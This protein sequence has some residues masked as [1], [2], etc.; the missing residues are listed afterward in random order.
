MSETSVWKG[1]L[2]T[3][4][5]HSLPK[6]TLKSKV[7]LL[8]NDILIT[9]DRCQEKSVLKNCFAFTISWS[10]TPGIFGDDYYVVS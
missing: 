2:F 9:N 10:Q 8:H 3:L 7:L 4:V 5:Y 6:V 1:V